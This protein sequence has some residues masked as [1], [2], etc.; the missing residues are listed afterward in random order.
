MVRQNIGFLKGEIFWI[1]LMLVT[2]YEVKDRAFWTISYNGFMA[3]AWH[4]VFPL[5]KYKFYW[6]DV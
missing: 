3:P 4:E 2:G 5:T 6:T 1:I